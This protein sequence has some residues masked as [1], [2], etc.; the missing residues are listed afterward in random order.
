MSENTKESVKILLTEIVDY[1]GLFPPSQLSMPEAVINYATYKN[2]NYK[3]MLGRFI[4]PVGRLEEFE[5]SAREF[6]PHNARNAW[7]LSIL[8]SDNIHE[9]IR[10]IEEFNIRNAPYAICDTLEI[11]A[12]NSAEI[13]RIA[14]A[15]PENFT[16]YFEVPL[17]ETLSETVSTLAINKQCGKIRT[18][19][20][21]PDLF[22]TIDEII[23]FIRTCLAANVAF[24]ATAGLH[25]PIRCFQPLTYEANAPKGRM[26]G[27]LNLFLA[28]GF[29][30]EGYKPEVVEQ[31][32][33]EEFEEVFRF[34]DNGAY[35]QKE[36]FLTDAKLKYLRESLITSFGSCSFDEPIQ[37]LQ[38]IGL[39]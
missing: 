13:E 33:E 22:P 20:V 23:R 38:K 24:K 39:L 25:H 1:A 16:N 29:A 21:T 31:I 4:C 35:W 8:V 14:G 10:I 37:D 17:D 26:H 6:F 3:W 28:T 2:S 36:Y 27:F 34:A 7:K 15:V 30:H 19:G 32:L 18:G 9:T 5:E 11:K 12:Q